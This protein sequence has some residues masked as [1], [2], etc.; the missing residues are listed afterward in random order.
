MSPE[1][2]KPEPEIRFVMV[3][4]ATFTERGSNEQYATLWQV[5]AQGKLMTCLGVGN[6][7]TR[8]EALG[9]A[10]EL[11]VE[12]SHI[13]SDDTLIQAEERDFGEVSFVKGLQALE[14]GG[15]IDKGQVVEATAVFL[16]KNGNG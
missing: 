13:S 1:S 10:I 11:A 7:E 9:S 3:E 8:E 2:L 14:K 5:D 4:Y 16:G 6:G 15:V 12:D